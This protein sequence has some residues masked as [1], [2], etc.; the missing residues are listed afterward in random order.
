MRRTRITATALIALALLGAAACDRRV[1]AS[2]PDAGSA[3]V[4]TTTTTTAV[5]A[6]CHQA[7]AISRNVA[8]RSV[9]AGVDPKLLSLDVYRLGAG[10]THAPVW[11]WVHGGGW[12]VGDKSFQLSD[13]I[14]LAR[15]QGWVLISVNYRL[16]PGTTTAPVTWPTHNNDVA[17]AVSWIRGHATG[18]GGDP[19]R[20]LLS[21]H[22]AGAAI[23]AG[24]AGDPRYLS[25]YHLTPKAVRCVAPLDTEGFDVVKQMTPTPNPIYQ[26]A[27]GTNPANWEAASP[28]RHLA[29]GGVVGKHFLVKRGEPARKAGVDAYVA[30]LKAAGTSATVVDLTGYSHEDVNTSLGKA[31]ETRETVPFVRWATSCLGPYVAA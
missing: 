14:A 11:I 18:L 3:A 20:L 22:S 28:V 6:S 29:P 10:C 7:G 1:T 5:P 9:P 16:S 30:A 26:Q 27:F 8:Y 19:N 25:P 15:K 12:Q 17:A 31:G 24:V 23:V 13:K 21:G 2:G 4:T